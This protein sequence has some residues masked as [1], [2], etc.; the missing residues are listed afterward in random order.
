M[1]AI[2]FEAPKTHRGALGEDSSTPSLSTVGRFQGYGG[3]LAAT[4][5]GE[6]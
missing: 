5:A 4:R 6:T 1:V 3:E 2:D